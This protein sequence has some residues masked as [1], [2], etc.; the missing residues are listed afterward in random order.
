MIPLFVGGSSSSV[1]AGCPSA[2]LGFFHLFFS[3]LVRSAQV[4]FPGAPAFNSSLSWLSLLF[5]A[6]ICL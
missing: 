1:L 2:F 4:T 5:P 6:G 3:S